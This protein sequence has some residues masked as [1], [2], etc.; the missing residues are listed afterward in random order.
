VNDV[1]I[2]TLT[3]HGSE[4]AQHIAEALGQAEIIPAQESARET[5]AGLFE[6]GRPLVCIMALG[7]VVRILGPLTRDKTTDPPVVV[8]DDAG[9]FAISVLGGHVGGANELAMRVADAI[10]GL[11]VIT[12]ASD[13]LGLP[14]VDIIGRDWGWKLDE[15][16]QMNK[17]A[18]AVVCGRRIGVFQ[19]AG[20]RDWGGPFDRWP[21]NF[22][23]LTEPICPPEYAGAIF[24]TDRFVEPLPDRRPAVLYRPPSLVL[25]VGCCKGIDCEALEAAFTVVCEKHG[26]SPRSLALVATAYLRADE[27]GLL[28]FAEHHEVPLVCFSLVE[29]AS[30]G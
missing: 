15:S 18:A 9:Q 1:A 21:S 11:P 28:E 10:D 26:L 20:R 22:H 5:L 30:V 24:I 25:G 7:I 3:P 27:A 8:V 16:R 2:V 17:L 12:T 4:L 19:D 29:L 13:A 14:P 6:A 23:S